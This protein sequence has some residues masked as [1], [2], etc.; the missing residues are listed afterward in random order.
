MNEHTLKETIKTL[1]IWKKGNQRAPHKPLLLLYTL[2]RLQSDQSQFIPYKQVKEKLTSLLIEF[3][4]KRKSYHPEE[5]FVRLKH[6]GI[7]ELRTALEL[8]TRNPNNR[9][10]LDHHVSG[11]FTDE[12]YLLLKD[13]HQLLCEIVDIL[14]RNH[15]PETL[16]EDILAHIG[17]DLEYKGKRSRD[18][19]FRERILTAYEYS[20]AVCGF[21]V[22]LG[23]KLVG[24]E[25]A[26]IKW[27]QAGGPDVENNGIALC[28]MHH[29]LFDRGV[30]TLSEE[31]RFLVAEEAHGTSGFQEWLLQ[32][33]GRGIRRPIHPDYLPK[34]RFLNWH[35]REVFKG[36]ERYL[37]G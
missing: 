19:Y 28:S 1:S 9:L 10:L 34:D 35:V 24:V 3:G 20:C 6:D 27:H 11:G 32:F 18:P 26:H 22:R 15:F 25:A 23:D 12:V 36:P 14:L 13:N 33:H 29:K 4:P 17:L 16:H 21:N 7:W 8:D 2:A 37:Y 30:F 31:N 5:P